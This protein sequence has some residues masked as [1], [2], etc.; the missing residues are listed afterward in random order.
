MGNLN[1]SVIT[2]VILKN[3]RYVIT[4][5]LTLVVSN[6]NRKYKMWEQTGY[7]ILQ[8]SAKA[9]KNHIIS[10]CGKSNFQLVDDLNTVADIPS[11]I[12]QIESV[13]WLI[14]NV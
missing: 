2:D 9:K 3:Y 8:C 6:S 13:S 5:N 7:V 10:V 11:T 4:K 1:C 12:A 14:L